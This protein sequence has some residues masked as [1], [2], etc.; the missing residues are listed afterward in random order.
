[1]TAL[2]VSLKLVYSNNNLP[3]SAYHPQDVACE[4]ILWQ[5]LSHPNLLPFYGLVEID[6]I[7]R[8]FVSPWMNNG[9]INE[10]LQREPKANR[11]L[12]VGSVTNQ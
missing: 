4:A 6:N 2:L 12:L 8:G 3:C 9:D 1:M 11:I 7:P 10:Y 5:Q